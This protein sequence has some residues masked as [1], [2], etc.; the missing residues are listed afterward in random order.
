M[1]SELDL[2]SAALVAHE[3]TARFELA[4][5]RGAARQFAIEN[6]GENKYGIPY[7]VTAD[8]VRSLLALPKM[9]SKKNNWMG[10]V[11]MERNKKGLRIWERSGRYHYSET[12]GSHGN[13]LPVWV[14]VKETLE[15]KGVI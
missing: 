5:A 1:T 15:A 12:P 13:H 14:L 3:D 2:F 4:Q 10:A 9:D 8:D 7:S 6:H 11:F